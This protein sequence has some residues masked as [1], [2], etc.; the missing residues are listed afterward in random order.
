MLKIYFVRTN[1]GNDI[2]ITDEST[3]KM[4]TVAPKGE[5]AGVD[6]YADAAAD[7]LRARF[8]E[9]ADEMYDYQMID[10]D[11]ETPYTPALDAELHNRVDGVHVELV[12]DDG[13][14]E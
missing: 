6:L 1:A 9:I 4:P 11:Y 12:Y 13:D 2:V 3:A 7:N 8:A 10:C 14:R 5:Y